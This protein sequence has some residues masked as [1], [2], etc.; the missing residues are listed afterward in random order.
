MHGIPGAGKTALSS[1]IIDDL[2]SMTLLDVQY[3]TPPIIFFYFSRN[4]AESERSCSNAAL[5]SLIRQMARTHDNDFLAP[6]LFKR[7]ANA[8]LDEDVP[9]DMEESVG[10]L[11]EMADK[12]EITTI[13]L[14]ALDECDPDTRIELLDCLQEVQS[15][16]ASLVKVFVTS[17]KERDIIEHFE[18][19]GVPGISMEAAITAPDVKRFIIKELNEVITSRRLLYGRVSESLRQL[20]EVTLI[21]QSQGM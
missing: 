13:V 10:I 19:H 15:S 12:H 17:R 20:I 9:P 1:I 5:R 6:A 4:T 18:E 14:D 16:S 3:S 11:V 21:E 8:S 7:Y 2:N